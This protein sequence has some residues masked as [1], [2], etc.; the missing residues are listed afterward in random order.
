MA[1]RTGAGNAYR[2][3][4]TDTHGTSLMT[5]DYNGQNPVWRQR[6]PFG[7]PRGTSTGTWPDTNG[8]LGKPTDTNKAPASRSSEPGTTTRST[9]SGR[10]I[11]VDP[12]LNESN[13]QELNGLHLRR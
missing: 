11:S 12:V 2:F 4:T 13:P 8:F 5:L 9:G 7:G 10:F 1:V 3:E 6:T